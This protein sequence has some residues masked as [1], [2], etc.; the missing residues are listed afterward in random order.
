[1]RKALFA[2][3][4]VAASFAGGAVI[5]GPASGWVKAYLASAASGS[6][7]KPSGDAQIT[8]EQVPS[9]PLP[10]LAEGGSTD[11]PKLRSEPPRFDPMVVPAASAPPAL[12]DADRSSP[13]SSLEPPISALPRDQGAKRESPIVNITNPRS[14]SDWPTIRKKLTSQG[15]TRYRVEVDLDGKTHFSCVIPVAGQ[16]A[17]GQHFEADGDDEFQAAETALKRIVLWKASE[18]EAE[19]ASEPRP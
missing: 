12:A 19:P 1:M 13:P 10:L 18:A 15:V 11:L 5:N 17:V 3:V 9:A 14:S 16:R 2:V 8:I 7:E 6:A 4:L